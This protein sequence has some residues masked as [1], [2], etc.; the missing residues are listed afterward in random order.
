MPRPPE[1]N[2]LIESY[3]QENADLQT[4]GVDHGSVALGTT[5]TRNI[6]RRTVTQNA[7]GIWEEETQT[8]I[9][10][11]ESGP[12]S[13]ERGIIGETKRRISNYDNVLEP[14]DERIVRITA[15]IN[16]NKAG[17][18]TQVNAAVSAGCSINEFT[19]SS[20]AILSINGVS[21][22]V[23]SH[24][25]GD[26]AKYKHYPNLKPSAASDMPFQYDVIS[27]LTLDDAGDG[28]ENLNQNNDNE[29]G[30]DFGKWQSVNPWLAP[31]TSGSN[32]TCQSCI[33]AMNQLAAGI[34][35]M[36][37]VR[38]IHMRDINVLKESRL[39]DQINDWAFKKEAANI[40]ERED[41][42]N[43][44]IDT[45]SGIEL[46]SAGIEEAGLRL[47][48]DARNNSSYGLTGTDWR[49]LSG[50]ARHAVM[51]GDRVSYNSSERAFEF[52]GTS[53]ANDQ[54][55]YITQLKYETGEIDQLEA[56]TVE[57]WV[58]AGSNP[59]GRTNDQRIILSFDRSAVFR[60][61]VGSNEKSGS[62]G[63]PTLG[64][65]TREG[66]TDVT[67]SNWSG[68]LR[69]DSWHQVAVTYQSTVSTGSSVSTVNFYVD[70]QKIDTK[71]DTTGQI[72]GQDDPETPRY[73]WIG[74]GSEA[75]TPGGPTGSS[76]MWFGFMG[77][78]VYYHKAL[79]DTQIAEHF[80]IYKAEYGL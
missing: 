55:I 51:Q 25:F 47:H 13:T 41:E 34:A 75:S 1:V 37:P 46:E 66:I 24:I 71:T 2:A 49:D 18:I 21:V 10:V 54:G 36:R 5:V 64:Y 22:G 44:L 42:L 23:G 67:A 70:G 40:S 58:K 15:N 60:F 78:L 56:I 32:A 33:D 73:G 20:S 9:G 63:K 57:A 61:G 3:K 68:N 59:T 77:R 43:D 12:E 35:T 8:D 31:N 14:L 26:T 30:T 16:A 69:D 62:A 28:Y 29:D 7:D 50:G 72:S 39:E 38:S 79:T 6:E 27:N 76:N 45:L 53:A 4:Y 48:F 17:I 80:D 74:N 52:S 11:F 65:I 19:G